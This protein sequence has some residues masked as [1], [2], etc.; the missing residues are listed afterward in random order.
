MLTLTRLLPAPGPVAAEDALAPAWS[1]G[2][3]PHVRVNM[4]ASIDGAASIGGR[5]GALTGPAD[6][7]LLHVLRSLCDVLLVGA[8]TVRAEGYGP[9]E[10]LPEL[11][12]RRREL[13]LTAAPRLAILS[14]AVDLDLAS[15]VFT[16][17]GERPLL[18]T[19][20]MASSARLAEARAVADV[21][22]VGERWAGL[23]AVIGLLGGLGLPRILSE[24]GPRLLAG[25]FADDLVDELCLAISPLVTAGSEL[26]ITN[27]PTLP[28]PMPMHLDAAFTAGD[29][30]LFTRY[31]RAPAS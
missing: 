30:F 1:A 3:A 21:V 20:A 5:V 10:V 16:G 4:V 19:T 13:G 9:I 14:R 6:Q 22:V 29:G 31:L 7:A 11:A 12:A 17:P 18:L 26:R 2:S 23:P 28:R 27:G 8:A 25:L 15:P 24:G